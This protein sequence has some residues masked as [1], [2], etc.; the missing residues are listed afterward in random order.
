MPS[1][2]S[3]AMPSH[4]SGSARPSWC[5]PLRDDGSC[6]I[7]V[8][9]GSQ[10]W[11]RM[12]PFQESPAMPTTDEGCA[13]SWTPRLSPRQWY[14]RRREYI[15]VALRNCD[16]VRV[17]EPMTSALSQLM[18]SPPRRG[19]MRRA[20]CRAPGRRMRAQRTWS[21]VADRQ[22][23]QRSNRGAAT[24]LAARG[25]PER[26]IRQRGVSRARRGRAG[27][28][29]AVPPCEIEGPHAARPE[30]SRSALADGAPH[31]LRWPR[32]KPTPSPAMELDPPH[33]GAGTIPAR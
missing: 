18:M 16:V 25:T 17:A 33:S 9:D 3:P 7:S 23:R 27:A 5:H 29:G 11:R 6:R 19:R 24:R 13:A 20:R 26:G 10:G 14:S 8:A 15:R 4:S 28:G 30:G 32:M 21:G 1:P 2:A 12:H 31:R 22:T